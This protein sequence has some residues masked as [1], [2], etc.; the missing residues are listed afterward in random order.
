MKTNPKIIIKTNKPQ[1]SFSLS[2]SFAL[3]LCDDS[4]LPVCTKDKENSYSSRTEGSFSD[5]QK[6]VWLFI[7]GLR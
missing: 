4:H 2:H 3:N 6:P 7:G 1:N 5:W